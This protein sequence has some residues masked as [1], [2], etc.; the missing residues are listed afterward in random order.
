MYPPRVIFTPQNWMTEQTVYIQGVD[1]YMYDKNTTY[2]ITVG[3]AVSSDKKYDNKHAET[4]QFINLD[5][6]YIGLDVSFA[7]DQDSG[8]PLNQTDEAGLLTGSLSARLLSQPTS[9]VLFT[10]STTRPGEASVTP[11][12]LSFSVDDWSSAQKVSVQGVQDLFRDFDQE[13]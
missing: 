8:L 12:I 3:P 6:D 11:S 9:T 7:F 5:N 2:T 13:Y 1:D 4:F 10:V